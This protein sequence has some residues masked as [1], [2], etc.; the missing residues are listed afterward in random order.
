MR[1]NLRLLPEEAVKE[2]RR[3]DHATCQTA[4]VRC[5]TV[6]SDGS[7]PAQSILWLFCWANNG[8]GS[9]RA[10]EQARQAFN[11]VFDQTYEWLAAR[12]TLDYAHS[13]RYSPGDID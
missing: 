11:K 12:I 4:L 10:A 1:L 9:T 3:I 6:R 8:M 13:R 5:W 7:V 2:L